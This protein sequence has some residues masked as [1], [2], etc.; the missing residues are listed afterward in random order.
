MGCDG[1]P[2]AIRAIG[3]P[4]RSP[5]TSLPGRGRRLHRTF[6]EHREGVTNAS[7]LTASKLASGKVQLTLTDQTNLLYV[8]GASTNLV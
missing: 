5:Q 1:L 8:F 4:A 6:A 2:V 7:S 3:T